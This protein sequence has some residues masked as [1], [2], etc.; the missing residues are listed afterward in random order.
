ML[1]IQS[2]HAAI[3]GNPILKGVDLS[4]EQGKSMW[5]WG[6][7]GQVSRLWQKF[8]LDI[9]LMRSLRDRSLFMERMLW[10]WILTLGLA[11]GS[12]WASSILQKSQVCQ[13]QFLFEAYN[14]MHNSKAPALL[15]E[16]EFEAI[17]DAKMDLFKMKPLLKIGLLMMVFQVERKK[18]VRFCRW[19]FWSLLAF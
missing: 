5:L 16:E 8:W 3:G 12:L 11:K 14:S 19:P 4:I 1:E 2:L 15:S 17:L 18:G 7:M 9:P 13:L 10:K 6:Q